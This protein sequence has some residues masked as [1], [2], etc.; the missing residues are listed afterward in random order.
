[1]TR[2]SAGA[3]GS[4]GTRPRD[5]TCPLVGRGRGRSVRAPRRSRRRGWRRA[6][7]RGAKPPGR[8]PRESRDRTSAGPARTS[9]RGPRREGST[10]PPRKGPPRSRSF[11]AACRSSASPRP[12][13]GSRHD[14]L[15][16][17]RPAPP[18]RACP[19]GSGEGSVSRRRRRLAPGPW[20]SAPRGDGA[21]SWG[22]RTPGRSHV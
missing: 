7:R 18:C 22:L 4:V 19:V 6:V 16:A 21:P 20:P 13:S 12:V 17:T 2:R 11:A 8:A 3:P 14:R 15:R 5:R 10:R 9:R 1:M